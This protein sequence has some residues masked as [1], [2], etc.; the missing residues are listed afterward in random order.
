ME[1]VEYIP[2]NKDDEINAKYAASVQPLRSK[3]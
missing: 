1:T 2:I 3:V